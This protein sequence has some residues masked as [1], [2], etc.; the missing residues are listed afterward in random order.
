M[1]EVD[2]GNIDEGRM[3]DTINAAVSKGY[4]ELQAAVDACGEKKG[5]KTTIALGKLEVSFHPEF[6]DSVRLTYSTPQVTPPSIKR[7]LL[8]TAANGVMLTQPGGPRDDPRQTLM[9]T[10]KGEVAGVLDPETGELTEAADGTNV[11]GKIA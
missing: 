3:L 2:I 7:K 4:A 5:L 9:F 6:P 10:P 1:V 8:A 11:A